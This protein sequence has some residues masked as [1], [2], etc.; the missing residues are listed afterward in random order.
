MSTHPTSN[1]NPTTTA[2][3]TEIAARGGS[4]E[5][6]DETE[7]DPEAVLTAARAPRQFEPTR[8]ER[9]RNLMD[10]ENAYCN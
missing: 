3:T 4:D 6:A 5:W 8:R 1:T 10:D 2:G 7:I 9:L